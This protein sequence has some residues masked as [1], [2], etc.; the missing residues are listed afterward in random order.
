MSDVEHTTKL[1]K[2]SQKFLIL[3]KILSIFNIYPF[4]LN[5]PIQ[6]YNKMHIVL[7]YSQA[8]S[9]SQKRRSLDCRNY[10]KIKRFHKGRFSL[11]ILSLQKQ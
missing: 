5:T 7:T 8:I 10:V 2:L 6:R 11:K 3:C 9:L 4:S 1:I